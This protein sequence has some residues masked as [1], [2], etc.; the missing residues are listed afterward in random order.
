MFECDRSLRQVL[1]WDKQ[2][3]DGWVG[4]YQIFAVQF[5]SMEEVSSRINQKQYALTFDIQ[6]RKLEKVFCLY[7]AFS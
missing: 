6:D 4:L 5:L 2:A 7:Q 1:F 3:W